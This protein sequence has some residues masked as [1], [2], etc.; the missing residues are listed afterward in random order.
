[1]YVVD[2]DERPLPRNYL[3]SSFGSAAWRYEENDN[4]AATLPTRSCHMKPVGPTYRLLVL[5]LLVAVLASFPRDCVS[6]N[7]TNPEPLGEGSLPSRLLPNGTVCLV[8][9]KNPTVCRETL[10]RIPQR[11]LKMESVTFYG[12]FDVDRDGSPEVFLRLLG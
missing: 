8:S 5:S 4:Q 6:A 11:I 12:V 7:T 2:R 1:M 10:V 9:R 3:I